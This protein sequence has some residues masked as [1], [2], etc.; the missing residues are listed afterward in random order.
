MTNHPAPE[1]DGIITT[2]AGSGKNAAHP[3]LVAGGPLALAR[4]V[5]TPNCGGA[6]ERANHLYQI[7]GG[8]QVETT[9]STGL[10]FEA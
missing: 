6:S 10:I 3:A 4:F 5:T 9:A 7:G 1:G 2:K 8:F